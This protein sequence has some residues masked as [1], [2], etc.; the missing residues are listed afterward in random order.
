[1][2]ISTVGRRGLSEDLTFYKNSAVTVVIRLFLGAFAK[3][4][5]ATISF[6]MSVRHSEWRNSATTGRIFMKFDTSVFFENM[7]RKLRFIKFYSHQLM[8]F[9]I[10]TCKTSSR[11]HTVRTTGILNI[12]CH[13]TTMD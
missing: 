9:F 2:G 7:W 3:L 6:V 10:Q 8:H 12:C 13:I 4:R 5:K 11:L 1:M